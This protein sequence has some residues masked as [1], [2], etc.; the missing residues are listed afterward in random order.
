LSMNTSL[1]NIQ[2]P[3]AALAVNTNANSITPIVGLHRRGN[4]FYQESSYA[5]FGVAGVMC[6]IA[7]VFALV[8]VLFSWTP[9][10]IYFSAGSF[11]WGGICMLLYYY[12]RNVFGQTIIIDPANRTL[13]ITNSSY[14]TDK[15]ISWD[16]IIE[17]QICFQPR[18]KGSK[19]GGGYQLNLAWKNK[20]S[21]K[22]ER[23]CLMKQAE[24][25]FIRSLGRQYE[26]LFSFKL[27]DYT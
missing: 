16:Q 1:E 4:P 13:R 15:E 8:G 12:F 19:M 26:S 10:L 22:I 24:R 14:V 5:F 21:E 25:R 2:I 9:V 27:A 3:C 23:H 7:A 17:L 18:Q 11:V 20:S 6:S